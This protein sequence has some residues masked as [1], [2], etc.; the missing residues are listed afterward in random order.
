MPSDSDTTLAEFADTTVDRRP[1]ATL[2]DR[3][4]ATRAALLEEIRLDANAQ[5]KGQG[6]RVSP[7]E[8]IANAYQAS[9]KK[10]AKA[11]G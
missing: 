6:L 5:L 8:A 11:P 9:A 2:E 10:Y 3:D 1:A 4:N 7:A